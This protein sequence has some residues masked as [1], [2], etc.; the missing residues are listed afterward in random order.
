MKDFKSSH[1]GHECV[2]FE[3]PSEFQTLPERL[4]AKRSQMDGQS[5]KGTWSGEKI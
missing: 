4:R 1:N 5:E 2:K 3:N